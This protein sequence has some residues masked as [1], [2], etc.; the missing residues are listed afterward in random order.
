M[1]WVVIAA[2]LIIGYLVVKLKLQ[3]S[4]LHKAQL[5]L[6]DGAIKRSI[7]EDSATVEAARKAFAESYK[8]YLE[9]KKDK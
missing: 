6:L 2:G 7:E 5:E 8:A 9:A 3:G 4:A 1:Q